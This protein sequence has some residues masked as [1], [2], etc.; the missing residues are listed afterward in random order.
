MRGARVQRQVR[1]ADPTAVS[2]AR[3]AKSRPRA[4]RL[5]MQ[6]F[7]Q[8]VKAVSLTAG[9]VDKDA[10]LM[11]SR[12]H[13]QRFKVGRNLDDS[14]RRLELPLPLVIAAFREL[15][16]VISRRHTDG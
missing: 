5:Q 10:P 8:A 13:G 3:T 11:F 9:Q 4:Q 14:S 16:H 6:P 2:P 7:G 1:L 12:A 15:H